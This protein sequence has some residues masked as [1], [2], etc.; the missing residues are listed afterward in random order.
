[1]ERISFTV[2]LQAA[3]DQVTTATGILRPATADPSLTSASRPG[4]R[5]VT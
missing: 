3:A 1:M 5:V 2:L 4:Q